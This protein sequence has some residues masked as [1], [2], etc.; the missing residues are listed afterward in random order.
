[1]Q[2]SSL[3]SLTAC[4]APSTEFSQPAAES[5]EVSTVHTHTT[6]TITKPRHVQEDLFHHKVTTVAPAQMT[7]LRNPT[8]S[9]ES[10]QLPPLPQRPEQQR[11][12]FVQ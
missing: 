10:S 5:D 3:Y 11:T 2:L 12:G 7:S 6:H 9:P 8:S 1:M 4:G